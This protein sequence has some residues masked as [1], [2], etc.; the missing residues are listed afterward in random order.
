MNFQFNTKCDQKITDIFKFHELH[1]FCYVG[2]MA[3]MSVI[4]V[5]NICHFGLVICFGKI[6]KK[7]IKEIVLNFM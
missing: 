2:T 1:I 7:W 4:Y 3:V 6:K 5:D